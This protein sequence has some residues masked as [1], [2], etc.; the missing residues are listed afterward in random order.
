MSNKGQVFVSDLT[1]S[2]T[3]F[4]FF[5]IFLGFAWNTSLDTF[6]NDDKAEIYRSQTFNNIQSEGYPTNWNKSNVQVPGI[7]TEGYV[8]RTKLSYLKNMSLNRQRKLLKAQEFYLKPQYLNDTTVKTGNKSLRINSS[9]V[10][11]DKSVYV[12]KAVLLDSK[13][14]KR[15]ML[16]YYRW[17][18]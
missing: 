15:V 4:S 2:I 11:D 9:Q 5:L 16:E 18:G 10:P 13:T 3:I 6:L 1:A 17:A 8:N 14:Q 7:L 12:E